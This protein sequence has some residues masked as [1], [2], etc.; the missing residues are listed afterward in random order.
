[1]GP[2]WAFLGILIGL[3]ALSTF[4]WVSRFPIKMLPLIEGAET[5]AIL[6]LSVWALFRAASVGWTLRLSLL[7]VG[8]GV[9]W[10]IAMVYVGVKVL[11]G[12]GFG[13][14]LA[15]SLK[16]VG[17]FAWCVGLG[18]LLTG[19][20]KDKNMLIPISIALVALDVFLVL[21][22]IGP[23]KI[24]LQ[25]MPEIPK[26]MALNLPK[27]SAT[28]GSAPAVPFAFIGPADFVFMS[29][30][31]I[32][33][34][35]FEMNVRRT[36]IALVPAM[37]VYMLLALVVGD[38]PLLVPIGLT[39]LAV[40]WPEFKLNGEEWASTALIAALAGG[41]IWYGATRKPSAP[42]PQVES[43]PSAPDQPPPGSEGSPAPANLGRS[44]S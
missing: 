4:L 40:N 38:V 7:M 23:V 10:H 39:V 11:G 5:V 30:F 32:A 20:I 41:L 34:Y 27:V 43:S 24:V 14:E 1:M 17:L 2:L 21:T 35:K 26:A 9:A 36:A 37:L 16:N 8:A 29:M 33:L 3:S 12:V 28:P 15:L 25:T 22:P 13:A 19:K 18:A 42:E 44:P 31:F 6:A